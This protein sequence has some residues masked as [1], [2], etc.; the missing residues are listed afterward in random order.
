MADVA[1]DDDGH[2]SRKD[3]RSHQVCRPPPVRLRSCRKHVYEARRG[4]VRRRKASTSAAAMET[5][6]IA[7][8]APR[9]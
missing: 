5:W 2:G 1:E 8:T 3:A 4:R 7:T 6:A 9:P